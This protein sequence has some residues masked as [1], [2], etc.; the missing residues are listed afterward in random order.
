[1]IL[2]SPFDRAVAFVLRIE[3]VWSDDPA[4]DGGPTKW[5]IASRAHPAI[6]LSTLTRDQAIAIYR[7][8]YWAACRCDEVAPALAVALF[9]CAVNQGP[10]TAVT[11]LQR[12]LG[13]RDDGDFGLLTLGAL[14]RAAVRPLL[15]EF[16][17]R[18]A[19]RYAAHADFPR[20]ARGWMRRL[21][22]VQQLALLDF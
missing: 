9:D 12:A 6:N 3:G 14:R 13:V 4:D 11:L 19:K 17:A 21:F 16:L 1:M 20:Y 22:L 7:R 15:V 5:G 10:R 18:R 2:R 8:E